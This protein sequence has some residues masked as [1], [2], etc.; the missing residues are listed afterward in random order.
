MVYD[1]SHKF[2]CDISVLLVLPLKG[3]TCDILFLADE[4]GRYLFW[5]PV[6]GA[7]LVSNKIR[8]ED[9]K[10]PFYESDN[11]EVKQPLYSDIHFTFNSL[12]TEATLFFNLGSQKI[13][14][15]RVQANSKSLLY[16]HPPTEFDIPYLD[17]SFIGMIKSRKPSIGFIE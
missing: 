15:I 16:L 10:L 4:R 12:N 13:L 9:M 1:R 11:Q 8:T 6:N 2:M 3:E 17:I 14:V 7:L 5:S